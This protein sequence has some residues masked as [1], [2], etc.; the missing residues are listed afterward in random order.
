MSL[1]SV[2]IFAVS[3][4]TARVALAAFPQ[5][6]L[7]RR[8]YDHLGTIFEDQDFADLFPNP[9]KP[10]PKQAQTTE[11]RYSYFT[12]TTCQASTPSDHGHSNSQLNKK[13][14]WQL[15]AS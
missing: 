14:R 13:Y 6:S 15:R 8:L 5:G 7:C 3:E 4:Q 9:D 1:R 12:P 2:P 11:N 10:E